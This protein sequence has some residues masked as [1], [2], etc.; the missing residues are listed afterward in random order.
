MIRRP[1]VQVLSRTLAGLVYGSPEFK[2][3]ATDVNSQLVRVLPVGIFGHIMFHLNMG[4]N[5]IIK[6]PHC[7]FSED[8]S[9][10]RSR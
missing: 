4:N 9:V 2:S 7:L 6:R 5:L 10:L 1:R 8:I 3:S